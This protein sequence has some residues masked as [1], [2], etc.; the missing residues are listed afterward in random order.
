[1][2]NIT[3]EEFLELTFQNLRKTYD[4]DNKFQLFFPIKRDQKP[5]YSEQEARV[6]AIK[7]CFDKNIKFSVE[8]PTKGEYF[9]SG[10]ESNKRSGSIDLQ[11]IIKEKY[12]NIEFKF[13]TNKVDNELEKFNE[14]PDNVMFFLFKNTDKGTIKTLLKNITN[15]TCKEDKSKNISPNNLLLAVYILETNERAIVKVNS[16][17]H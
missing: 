17:E 13:G 10:K 4:T 12:Y 1:M 14:N 3:I 9:F 7:T 15:Y 6:C 2:N 16:K 11:V 5:R 8:T